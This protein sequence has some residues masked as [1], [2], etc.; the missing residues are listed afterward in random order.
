MLYF[1]GNHE[2][3][4]FSFLVKSTGSIFQSL[5]LKYKICWAIIKFMGHVIWILILYAINYSYEWIMTS[6]WTYIAQY[7][8]K[9]TFLPTG[10]EF[11]NPDFEQFLFGLLSVRSQSQLH[12]SPLIPPSAQELLKQ[13]FIVNTPNARWP[14]F[15]ILRDLI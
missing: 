3:I 4:N 13:I 11:S 7:Y 8:S 14:I 2:F 12:H 6:F 10:R 15:L 9:Y 5:M 1:N